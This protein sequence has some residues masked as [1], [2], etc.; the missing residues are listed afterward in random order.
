MALLLAGCSSIT[1]HSSHFRDGPTGITED[2]AIALVL[3]SSAAADGKEEPL[4][5]TYRERI[6]NCVAQGM[7]SVNA[8]LL[9]AD[10]DSPQVR[11]RIDLKIETSISPGRSPRAPHP[12]AIP[13]VEATSKDTKFSGAVFDHKHRREIGT[14]EAWASGEEH[15]GAVLVSCSFRFPRRSGPI[16]NCRLAAASAGNWPHLLP[17][18]SPPGKINPRH[19][20]VDHPRSE[21][22]TEA[23]RPEAVL[24]R[25]RGA[26]GRI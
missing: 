21:I 18:A 9:M 16:R 14:V 15:S 6:A 4:T 11:Y 7:S 25:S 23:K 8:R 12:F 20:S 13:M 10:E 1:Q 17:K 22:P 5:K 26:P 2:E 24:A 19:A 3:K